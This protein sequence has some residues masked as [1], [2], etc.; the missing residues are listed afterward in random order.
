M[1]N[2]TTLLLSCEVA[3]MYFFTSLLF[4]SV[5]GILVTCYEKGRFWYVIFHG[6]SILLCSLFLNALADS[7]YAS[8][9]PGWFLAGW[10]PGFLLFFLVI[11][12]LFPLVHYVGKK[13]LTLLERILGE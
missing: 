13:Y 2:Q 10:L 1:I 8:Y 7:L 6:I 3:A 12:A 4:V 11:L 9:G 5:G